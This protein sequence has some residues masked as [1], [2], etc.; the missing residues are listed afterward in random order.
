[1]EI[2]ARRL[3][4]NVFLGEYH[5][6]FRGRGIEFSEVRQYE[7]GDDVR[8]I[9]WNVTARMGT[10]YVKKYIEERELTVLLAVDVSASSAFTSTGTTKRDLAAEVAATLAFAAVAN[11]DRVGLVAFSD[12]IEL[13]VPPAKSRTHVLRIVRE[14][15]YLRP[16]GRGTSVAGAMSYVARVAHR[17]AIVFMLS[18]FF[19]AG[20]E[21]QLRAA[22]AR[23][24]I[25]ALTLNDR[26]EDVLP[27]VGVVEVEDTESRERVIID[28]SDAA[29]R[30]VYAEQA[31]A[32]R[33]RRRRA[34][35]AAGVDEIALYT[36]RSYVEPLLRAFRA[37]ERRQA[38]RH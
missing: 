24:E 14:L 23:H 16:E 6:V 4:A 1:M 19:D 37:R 2:R 20:Y 29:S 34:L 17:R 25:L 22:A 3:V 10:P 27:D 12:R 35:A 36:G 30:A 31:V 38:V 7:P 11:N 28:S 32:R 21:R 9:D 26:R 8:A 18:D 33:A 13:F 5:S 15:L